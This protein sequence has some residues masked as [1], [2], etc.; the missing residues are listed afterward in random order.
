MGNKN[1]LV[2][3]REWLSIVKV[4][5]ERGLSRV[6]RAE[7]I[8]R[9]TGELEER[10]CR[11]IGLGEFRKLERVLDVKDETLRGIKDTS[12]RDMLLAVGMAVFSGRQE[13]PV[14]IE[15]KHW[16]HNI[17]LA[18]TLRRK[19]RLTRDQWS[20]G[21]ICN[22]IIPRLRVNGRVSQILCKAC[23]TPLV[24]GYFVTGQKVTRRKESC[25]N[26]CKMMAARRHPL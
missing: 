12:M 9:K 24:F 10:H 2:L 11:E 18:K 19:R 16:R 14:G 7:Y 3:R 4:R 1:D 21:E 20:L 15:P 8:N 5:G 13:R 6:Y 26:A 22:A 23:H 17:R 25:S